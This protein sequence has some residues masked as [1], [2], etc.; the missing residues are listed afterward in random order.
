MIDNVYI[1]MK[2][3]NSCEIIQVCTSYYIVSEQCGLNLISC[4]KFKT[5]VELYN[6]GFH[7]ALKIFIV[8]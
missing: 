5:H 1:C 7:F 6:Y 2:N 3:T 4:R 8:V